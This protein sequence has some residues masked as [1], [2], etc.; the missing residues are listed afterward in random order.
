M[1]KVERGG[2]YQ[3]QLS[4]KESH[5]LKVRQ[6]FIYRLPLI[7]ESHKEILKVEN[8]KR[9]R[10]LMRE[11]DIVFVRGWAYERGRINSTVQER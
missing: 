9:I 1:N 10:D 11:C 6:T 4:S 7:F 2:D 5:K 8:R 3:Q